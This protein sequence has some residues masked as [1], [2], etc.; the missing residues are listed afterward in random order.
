MTSPDNPA[1]EDGGEDGLPRSRAGKD[2]DGSNNTPAAAGVEDG[3]KLV[4]DLLRAVRTAQ[5]HHRR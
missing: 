2:G 1:R 5:E 3:R 4:R